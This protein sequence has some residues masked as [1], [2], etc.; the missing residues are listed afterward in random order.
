MPSTVPDHDEIERKSKSVGC[1]SDPAI[2]RL[3]WAAG[4]ARGGTGASENDGVS[5]RGRRP[6]RPEKPSM[7]ADDLA[8]LKK[9]LGAARDRQAPKGKSGPGAG[10]PA[11]Y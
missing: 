4:R 10:Q 9:N 1:V 2:R 8:K 7:T 5:G 3:A 11:K 6:P